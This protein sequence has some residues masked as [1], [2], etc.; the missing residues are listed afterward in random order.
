MKKKSF[1]KT[2][3]RAFSI[4]I[5]LITAFFFVSF[6]YIDDIVSYLVNKTTGRELIINGGTDF[7]F[8][9][10]SAGVIIEDIGFS[11][12]RWGKTSNMVKVGSLDIQ[13]DI[14]ELLNG[15]VL[16]DHIIINDLKLALEMNDRGEGNW[17]IAL[18]D[19]SSDEYDEY[20]EASGERD[21]SFPAI[22]KLEIGNLSLSYI[23]HYSKYEF[24]CIK[25]KVKG[26]FVFPKDN[27]SLSLSGR[28]KEKELSVYLALN[29]DLKSENYSLLSEASY[30]KSKIAVKG[31]VENVNKGMAVDIVFSGESRD[32]KEFI[33]P[34]GVDV[35]GEDYLK[36]TTR[37][38]AEEDRYSLDDLDLHLL[39]SDVQGDISIDF[40]A[41]KPMIKADLVSTLLDLKSF[42]LSEPST[43]SVKQESRQ[44]DDESEEKREFTD[45]IKSFE[46]ELT[47]R[48][49]RIY[50]SDFDMK[51]VLLEVI[52]KEGLL[53][54]RELK[55]GFDR[56]EFSAHALFDSSKPI[57]PVEINI[58]GRRVDI[59]DLLEGMGINDLTIGGAKAIVSMKGGGTDKNDLLKGLSGNLIFKDIRF[60]HQKEKDRTIPVHIV[61]IE[62]SDIVPERPFKVKTAGK[63]DGKPF[64]IH[65]EAG[66]L[67][68]P[69]RNN[70][71]P[72]KLM[73]SYAGAAA[74]LKG[75]IVDPVKGKGISL[76]LSV[77]GSN[78]SEFINLPGAKSDKPLPFSLSTKIKE[79]KERYLIDK[80]D[81]KIGES[82]IKGSVVFYSTKKKPEIALKL[83][84]GTLNVTP[85]LP[86]HEVSEDASESPPDF[87][88]SFIEELK[89]FNATLALNLD[90]V[91]IDDLIVTNTDLE[92]TLKDGILEVE[93]IYAYANNGRITGRGELNVNTAMPSVSAG[94]SGH[95][96]NLSNIEEFTGLENFV[97]EQILLDI[98]L[99]GSD[100]V[101]NDLLTGLKGAVRIKDGGFDYFDEESGQ[102]LPVIIDSLEIDSNGIHYPLNIRLD[103]GYNNKKIKLKGE[104]SLI[105][106]LKNRK[107]FSTAL[108]IDLGEGRLNVKGTIDN[109]LKGRRI[110]LELKSKGKNLS[111]L[112]GIINI[113]TGPIGPYNVI[114]RIRERDNV[115]TI[116]NLETHLEESDI[117]GE[118]IFDLSNEIP[119]YS[120]NI[121]SD[122]LD[123]DRLMILMEEEDFSQNND[124][125]QK[126]DKT[127]KKT[128]KMVFINEALPFGDLQKMNLSVDF[129]GRHMAYEKFDLKEVG[130]SF[131]LDRSEFTI[132]ELSASI[133][134]GSLTG[135]ASLKPIKETYQLYLH[136]EGREIGIGDLTES[137]ELHG[138]YLD[139]MAFGIDLQSSGVSPREIAENLNGTSELIIG[140]GEITNKYFNLIGKSV[141][142]GFV[143]L[144][145]KVDRA[146]LNC[147]VTDFEI[148]DGLADAEALILDTSQITIS[149]SGKIDLNDE[150]LDLRLSPRAK[151]T[152]LMSLALPVHIKGTLLNQKF[153]TD[154][155]SVAKEIGG[156]ALGL[157]NPLAALLTTSTFEFTKKHPCLPYLTKEKK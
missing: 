104:V 7:D 41:V 93:K 127:S 86:H 98:N 108:T 66:P 23:N 106:D 13:L 133:E 141:L 71:I 67:I 72:L 117:T 137:L 5:L 148:K 92:V 107:S 124:I 11:N 135:A 54:V 76:D 82:D 85:F 134:G 129:I 57:P 21:G 50:A 102:R 89:R 87:D 130:L 15:R 149:G 70:G 156:V 34:F 65:G 32:V 42:E 24:S 9:F 151:K 79:D 144:L 80:M 30:G 155:L 48:G 62:I 35:K 36:F 61:G 146:E 68:E 110:N 33:L 74:S 40:S 64:R 25:A 103:A 43:D 118:I 94:F 29:P 114:A 26:S 27:S 37:I 109:P 31:A 59:G 1:L 139:K 112:L 14:R 145:R 46:G 131:D 83:K 28:C 126:K 84:S 95:T 77:K 60:I 140:G 38:K 19:E 152:T 51:N 123:I 100:I 115:I 96:I 56:G 20:K 69:G 90:K 154:K 119:R 113:N 132:S 143:D 105:G 147:F 55:G 2:I 22:E 122:F 8:S 99:D 47:F 101:N 53:E 75:T 136:L 6:L 44:F 142:T 138:L 4:F 78:L 16:F 52:L 73:A 81:I 18:P 12:A 88:D 121:S 116:D 111:E 10:S 39:G 63:Y 17:K 45:I 157:I 91:I 128:D 49:G 120:M 58:E 97:I 3:F 150:T 153:K 125:P